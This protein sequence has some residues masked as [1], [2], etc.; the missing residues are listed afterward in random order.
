LSEACWVG[1]ASSVHQY[2]QWRYT[3]SFI[4]LTTLFFLLQKFIPLIPN[5]I[6]N[7]VECGGELF[8]DRGR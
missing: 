6:T 8:P 5:L 3:Q 1:A 2:Q 7:F 4:A